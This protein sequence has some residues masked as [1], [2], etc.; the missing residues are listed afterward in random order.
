MKLN[1]FAF[2]RRHP[3]L[4]F[5]IGIEIV[6]LAAL[7]RSLQSLH[8]G[9]NEAYERGEDSMEMVLASYTLRQSSDYLTR[10]AR[11][12][13]VTGEPAYRDMYQQVLNIRRGEALRPKDYES[14]Y[15]D[16]TEP[17]RSNAHPLLHPQ[18]L[19]SILTSLPFTDR[20][21]ELL[22]L[23]EQQSDTLAEL[24]LKAFDAIEQGDQEAAIEALF[25]V[26]YL[27]G[28]HEVM[29]PIDEFM[30][31]IRS[32]MREE[33]ESSLLAA[34]EQVQRVLWMTVLILV[35][36]MALYLRWPRAARKQAPAKAG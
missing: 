32:R 4:T 29:K 31:Q 6:L 15:W 17:Y 22:F 3:W 20:E 5:L 26:D 16:L 18:S 27:R 28:K 34:E 7:G 23:A 35:V 2:A 13:A 36:N 10:F 24:E 19:E 33:R 9:I 14:I 8:G 12:Y 30:T 11:N 21:L 1:P 25:S